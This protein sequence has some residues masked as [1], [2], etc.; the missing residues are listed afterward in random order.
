MLATV[1]SSARA[2]LEDGAR[3]YLDEEEMVALSH[4]LREYER[5]GGVV[6]FAEFLV[7]LLDTP[8][9]M[10]LLSDIRYTHTLTQ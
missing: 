5:N 4:R 9:K 6:S 1:S 10:Q 2:L 8:I 3:R 7:S